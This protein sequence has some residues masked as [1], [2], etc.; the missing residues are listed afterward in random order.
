[1]PA[2]PVKFISCCRCHVLPFFFP[3]ITKPTHVTV[4]NTYRQHFYNNYVKNTSSLTGII[5]AGIN[6]GFPTFYFDYSVCV[7]LVDK[8]FQKHFYSMVNMERSSSTMSEM[9]WD[10]VLHNSNIQ[11]ACMMFYNE[12]GGVYNT[13]FHMKVL[14]KVIEPGNHGYPTGWRNH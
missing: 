1:M 7:P 4:S 10:N 8:L 2:I 9:N 13:W 5:Y 12:F 11:D 3:T 14:S 6:D